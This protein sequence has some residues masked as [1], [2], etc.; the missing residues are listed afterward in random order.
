MKY[1]ESET[2]ELKASLAELDAALV[3]ICALLNHRGGKLYF[4]VRPDGRVVGLTVADSTFLKISQKIRQKLKPE[5]IPEI[6]ERSEGGKSIVEVII[7]E[8]T[9]KPYFVDGVAYIRSGS[10]S[11]KMPP[12]ML[13]HLIMEQQG[14]VWDR[15]ICAVASFDDIDPA[16]VK[17][18]LTRALQVRHIDLDPDT[19]VE[20]ALESLELLKEGKLTNAAIL[21]FCRNPQKFIDT[22]VIHCAKFRG[23]DVTQPYSNMKVIRGAI[24]AQIDQTEQFIRD[25]IAKAAWMPKEKFEREESWEYPPDAFREAVINAVCHRDYQSPGNVQVSIFTNSLEIMNPGLLPSTLTIESL[26]RR[27][28]SKP[29]NRLIAETLFKI[30][31]IEKFGSGTTKMI[32]VCRERG[33]PEPEFCEQDEDFMVTFRRSSV[34]VL[35]DQPQLLNERQKQAIEYLKTHESITTLEYVRLVRCHERTARKDLAELIRLNVV[36]KNGMGKLTR[37]IIHSGFRYFPVADGSRK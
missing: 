22:A 13:T 4:G 18:Y 29:R 24:V 7:S 2:V 8:G 23:D 11:V 36:D 30:K 9:H 34:N 33:V 6:K 25:N 10:E 31:Y 17:S 14:Y 19:P 12:D 26:K 37:Y 20:T 32:R 3:D 27:H 21:L 15:A 16:L 28:S 35:L 5:I 1:Q